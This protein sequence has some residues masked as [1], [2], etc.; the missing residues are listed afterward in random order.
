MKPA[1]VGPV[2]AAMEPSRAQDLTVMLALRLNVARKPVDETPAV[3]SQ[4]APP[5]G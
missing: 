2:M 3:Q 1:K 4:P 5:N